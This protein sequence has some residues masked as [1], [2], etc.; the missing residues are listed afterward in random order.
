[1]PFG[2]ST[3]KK[4]ISALNIFTAIDQKIELQPHRINCCTEKVL[5]AHLSD[6]SQSKLES[7]FEDEVPEIFFLLVTYFEKNPQH[8]LEEGLFRLQ[9]DE[10]LLE[11]IE[12]N[13]SM[14]NYA[15]LENLKNEPHAV[16]NF[17]KMVLREMSEP[18]CPFY[19]YESF[20]D[21]SS[22]QKSDRLAPIKNLVKK[23]P[24]LNK[25]VLTFLLDFF[26]KVI[27]H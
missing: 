20:R 23:M 10:Q 25:N 16:A 24:D 18:L 2:G 17:L 6:L 5:G 9:A 21:L 14:R 3:S 11:E 1:M 15:I 13:I 4:H 7:S 8:L 22:L 26:K 19:L 27:D 12:I